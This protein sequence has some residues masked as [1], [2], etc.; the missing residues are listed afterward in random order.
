MR[1]PLYKYK[2]KIMELII[3]NLSN[4]ELVKM[5][6]GLAAII[7]AII[8]FLAIII[9]DMINRNSEKCK[10]LD[11]AELK[12]RHAKTEA[13]IDNLLKSI[14]T[15]HTASNQKIISSYEGLWICLLKIRKNIPNSYFLAYTILTKNE[16]KNLS[17][18][19]NDICNQ[20]KLVKIEN[21]LSSQNDYLAEAEMYRPF[22]GNTAW[23]IFF[24][25]HLFIGRSLN[26]LAQILHK[27]GSTV[28][29]EDTQLKEQILSLVIEKDKLEKLIENKFYAF[30]NIL[31]YLE[32]LLCVEIQ[33]FL[34]GRKL[35]SETLNQSIKYS[36]AIAQA[37]KGIT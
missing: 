24:T 21:I 23:N 4:Y 31:I 35:A 18:S 16:I 7:S 30:H 15:I 5:L 33:S 17:K 3:G 37:N 32:Q 29:Y 26:L 22:I 8:S 12:H 14:S 34:L 2:K 19:D 28:W 27:N 25:Y 36:E 10:E 1:L 9:R 13:I 20:C 6:G 11:L